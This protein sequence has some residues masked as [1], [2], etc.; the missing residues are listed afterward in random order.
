MS[1]P[2][3]FFDNDLSPRYAEAIARLGFRTIVLRDLFPPDIKDADYLRQ[4][5]ASGWVLVTGDNRIL[6]RPA[7]KSALVE[8]GVTAVFLYRG[9]SELP[10]ERQLA[11]LIVHWATVDTFVRRHPPGTLARLRRDGTVQLLR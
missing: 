11:W 2:A 8:S 1:D 3:Y 9:W 7:E 6:A 5:R 10:F 4:L